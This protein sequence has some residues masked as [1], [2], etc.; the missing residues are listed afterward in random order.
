MPP[1]PSSNSLNYFNP[2]AQNPIRL[3][4]TCFAL[5]LVK[6]KCLKDHTGKLFHPRDRVVVSP[7]PKWL[8]NA[9][10]PPAPVISSLPD[11]LSSFLASQHRV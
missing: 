8:W 4:S 9:Y 5:G 2:L 3:Q 10:S 7:P 6:M 11:Q 1:P